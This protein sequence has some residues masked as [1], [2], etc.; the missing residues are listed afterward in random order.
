MVW[1][2]GSPLSMVP[3]ASD[4]VVGERVTIR[5]PERCA[6]LSAWYGRQGAVWTK[7]SDAPG[8]DRYSASRAFGEGLW[9]LWPRAA[10]ENGCLREHRQRN[11]VQW[12]WLECSSRA[13][14]LFEHAVDRKSTRLNSSHL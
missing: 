4:K 14:L 7:A 1:C 11:A 9:W 12:R 10:G 3:Y 8:S 6:C 2:A 13:S 5:E